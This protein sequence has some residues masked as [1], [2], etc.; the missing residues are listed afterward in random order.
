MGSSG[1][2]IC[3]RVNRDSGQNLLSSGLLSKNIPGEI[4]QKYNYVSCFVRVRSVVSHS[5]GEIGRSGSCLD[6][7]QTR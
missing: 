4:I 2:N 6:L 7:R 1:V 5:E 3:M